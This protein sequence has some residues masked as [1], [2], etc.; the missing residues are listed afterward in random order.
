M[1]WNPEEW[2]ELIREVG[3]R[4]V[5]LTSTHHEGSLSGRAGN[6][7]VKIESLS[8]REGST[9]QMLG[10]TGVLDWTQEGENFSVTLPAIL[11]GDHAYTLRITP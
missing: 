7:T 11:P 4:Y 5:V 6:G 2:A 8:V 10:V 9:I 1:G 3:A